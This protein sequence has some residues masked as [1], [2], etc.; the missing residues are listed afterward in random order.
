[1]RRLL[2]SASALLA[3]GAHA[4]IT[5]LAVDT[6]TARPDT[7][8]LHEHRVL[9]SLV[10]RDRS[11][12]ATSSMLDSTLQ[13]DY[14][15]S[16]LQGALAWAPGVQMDTR[17]LG[18]S[19]RL[20]IRGSVLRA[21]FGVR[22]VKVYW[23]PFPITLA[24]GTTPLELLDPVVIG[25]LE[26]VR[27][28][29][30]PIHGSAPAGV[31]LA[32]LPE[33]VSQG[34]ALSL[35]YTRGSNGFD[36]A[37]GSF[38]VRRKASFL[39][40]G[41]VWQENK[42]Y[43]DQEASNKQQAFLVGGANNARRSL[44]CAATF[45]HAYW[46]LPGSLDSLTAINT[47]TTAN[48]W[49]QGINAHVDKSQ[50]FAGAEC[51]QQVGRQWLL[52]AT[53]TGQYID[54]KNPYGTSSFFSG[55]KIESYRAFGAKLCASGQAR[56][57]RWQFAWEL[58]AESLFEHDDLLD[59]AYGSTAV[60]IGARTNAQFSATNATPYLITQAQYR[61][62]LWLFAGVG[63]ELNAYT[64]DDQLALRTDDG[65]GRQ[66]TWPYVG[67]RSQIVHSIHLHT[68]YAEAV[69][70]P[71]ITE[72]WTGE[73]LNTALRP[74]HIR[75]VELAV[76]VVNPDS[77]IRASVTGFY[78]S[79]SDRIVTV[80]DPL[81]KPTTINSGDAV[82]PG[83]EAEGSY[84][85]PMDGGSW[86]GTRVFA[87][88]QTL[89]AGHEANGAAQQLAGLP[90]LT[91]GIHLQLQ[92]R[93]RWQF[94]LG[95][96]FTGDMLTTD[97]GHALSRGAVLCSARIGRGFKVA[98]RSLVEFFVLGENLLDQRYSSWV[99]VNDPNGRYY[100]PAPGRSFFGGVRFCSR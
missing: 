53:I 87:S 23:G 4:Q 11:L 27:S 46:Q 100:N 36:R 52:R 54:K 45:Q 62:R 8:Q 64:A 26:V 58:G 73:M 67:F 85:H 17:G 31:L 72:V 51:E 15:R 34:P 76:H 74:E 35:A 59:S 83:L 14:E 30:S 86:F 95:T 49:S 66:S 44:T 97:G 84:Q 79:V 56:T 16:S 5:V 90:L 41:A 99:Q 98:H 24:D 81:G 61:D 22:G 42:G 43:R 6:S 65:I 63:A 60:L 69:S 82:M 93:H 2:L 78:R 19:A 68:R 28:I 7:L 94:M 71:T 96:R 37:E 13:Y 55:L 48:T 39:S 3:I 40:A 32:G 25:D 1:M 21:P 9:G 29:G 75:E 88:I 50:L 70:R 77:A 47:P 10:R 12:A 38:G 20:S 57:R 33:P 92:D 80:N 91:G 89:H 18:G